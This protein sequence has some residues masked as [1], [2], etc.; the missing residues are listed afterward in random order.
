MNKSIPPPFRLSAVR[1]SLAL[2]CLVQCAAVSAEQPET[3]LPALRRAIKDLT[4]TFESRYPQGGRFLAELEELE[5]AASTQ[6][7]IRRP[8][9]ALRR[10]AL[11]ANPLL[12]FNEILLVKRPADS[13]SLGLPQNW[14]S[15]CSLQRTGYD[16]ALCVLSFKEEGAEPRTLF[17]PGGKF[18][19]DVDLHWDADRVLFSMPG[20]DGRW[21]VSELNLQK[22]PSPRQLTGEQ[23]DVD[24]YDA[25]YLPNGRIAFTSTAS[26]VGVPCVNGS[27]HVANIYQMNADGG[28]TRQIC[29]DQE[30]NW[31]PTAMNDG[32]ILY[33]R[34]EY[35]DT[36]HSNSRLLFTMNPDGTSQSAYLGSGSY[37]PNSFFYARP[38]PG[39]PTKVV[40]VI[41]GHHDHPRMGELV[42]FDPQ[43]G[44]HEGQPAVQRIPGYGKKVEPLIRDGL[45]KDSWPKFLHPWPLSEKYF[46]V[47]CKRTPQ[48]PWGLCLAD[49]FDN[50]LPL[51]QMPDFALLEPI[52]LR[53]SDPPPVIPDRIDPARTDA[54]VVLQDIYAGDGLRG[55]P[56]GT[57]K[58]LRLFTYHYAYQGMG[59]LLGVV[60]MDGPWDIKRVLGTVP[61]EADG[62]ACF[63][64]PANT[65]ISIQPLDAEGKALQLMRSWMTA[66]PGETVQCTGC[67]DRQD[68]TPPAR[69]FY[70]MHKE[71][72]LITPWHGPVRGFSYPRD[73]QPV[74]D[75]H[76]VGCHDGQSPPNGAPI[77]DLRGTE[78]L[79][80][81]TSVT[82]GNGG[83]AKTA[84][85]F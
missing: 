78:M 64:V 72:S 6:Q 13:P 58:E 27:A 41:G 25:C 28:Q 36:P 35:A 63:H 73:V 32:R 8:F 51:Q 56:R 70:A 68:R 5:K 74:I 34:W 46:L 23:P 77:P 65:P 22:T 40:S 33:A 84:G 45:T 50:L 66:M 16:D 42:I 1:N 17:K 26:F 14:Q 52:P 24:S 18:V 15:N 48:S 55:V 69:E 10:K 85:K 4:R 38:V 61:V 54:L 67:H 57:V 7:D 60:G 20:P 59:G 80:D 29:F 82:P 53:K 43:Q 9:L 79:T 62:S 39:H 81:W 31:C 19:G 44:R 3:N 49:I 47:A 21:Q 37:W 12:D 71:P 11:L 76:C 75:R 30:H 83:Y 2:L